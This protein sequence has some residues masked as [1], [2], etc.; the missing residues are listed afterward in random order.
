MLSV[1]IKLYA[2]LCKKVL[3]FLF[4]EWQLEM[5][6]QPSFEGQVIR[7][8]SLLAPGLVPLQLGLW[9]ATFEF[10]PQA[11]VKPCAVFGSFYR[12]IT[13]IGSI[14]F[15]SWMLKHSFQFESVV[16]KNF[17][18]ESNRTCRDQVYLISTIIAGNNTADYNRFLIS[19]PAG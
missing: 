4:N 15:F 5:E 14:I 12:N 2:D 1:T 11:V 6:F 18:T 17:L 9:F 13:H 10:A 19:S 7:V 16:K 3:V 8:W